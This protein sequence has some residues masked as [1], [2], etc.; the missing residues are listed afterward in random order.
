VISIAYVSTASTPMSDEGIAA[1]L[2]SSRANNVR[3]G[4]T[5]ALLYH[6]GKFIQILEG[7][8][9]EVLARFRVIRADPRHGNLHE[10]SREAIE[11]RQ[12]GEWTMGFSALS[13]QAMKQLDGFDAYFGHTGKVALKSAD[14]SAQLFLEW[15]GEYWF[16]AA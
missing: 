16:A 15:L 14:A 13:E 1:I 5:G 7:P 2:V 11:R 10:V 8:E 12:F 6:R 9:E 4:L 3:L